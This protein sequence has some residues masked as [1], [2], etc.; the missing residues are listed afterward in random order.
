MH[1]FHLP[2]PSG[3]LFGPDV[4]PDERASLPLFSEFRLGL[5][6]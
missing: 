2:D 4:S 1:R 5:W 6:S 3:S